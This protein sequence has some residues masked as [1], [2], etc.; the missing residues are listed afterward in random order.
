MTRRLF[1]HLIRTLDRKIGPGLT[2]LRGSGFKWRYRVFPV[3]WLVVSTMVIGDGDFETCWNHAPILKHVSKNHHLV[4][5]C[6]WFQRCFI[7][8]ILRDPGSAAV[9]LR[10]KHQFYFPFHNYMGYIILPIDFHSIIF[11]GRYTT[12]QF[13]E[14]LGDFGMMVLPDL[15]GLIGLLT[16]SRSSLF[17]IAAKT[18][19]DFS[20]DSGTDDGNSGRER[21]AEL[22]EL[23]NYA[24]LISTL[25][26]SWQ[27][28]PCLD[29]S[30]THS[31]ILVLFC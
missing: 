9:R 28:S 10:G 15:P 6:W 30:S 8:F 17:E 21:S 5:E 4:I 7:S 19:G 12:K 16:A 11:Q 29:I 3:K 25:D 27:N 14:I 31:K 20:K 2:K 24:K 26:R 13:W 22:G 18:L 23:P 1:N